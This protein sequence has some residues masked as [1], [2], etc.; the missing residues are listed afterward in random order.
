M[1]RRYDQSV[2]ASHK[3][4]LL[5]F[6]MCNESGLWGSCGA[7]FKALR[8]TR[9]AH[10]AAWAGEAEQHR[11]G[12]EADNRGLRGRGHVPADKRQKALQSEQPGLCLG[13]LSASAMPAG[14]VLLSQ[15]RLS[16]SEI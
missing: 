14:T 5:I 7:L 9:A 6:G 3:P 1:L 4:R 8:Q 2:W 13:S 12:S 15:R 10:A 16:R 11:A